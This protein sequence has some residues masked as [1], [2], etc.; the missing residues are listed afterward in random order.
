VIQVV[1]ERA[2]E[3]LE[4]PAKKQRDHQEQETDRRDRQK[5]GERV[6]HGHDIHV[7]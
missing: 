1:V 2:V 7:R 5:D 3:M 6:Q 4:D